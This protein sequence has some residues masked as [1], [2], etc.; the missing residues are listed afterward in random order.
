MN[1]GRQGDR[2]AVGTDQVDLALVLRAA[3]KAEAHREVD[4]ARFSEEAP[5]GEAGRAPDPARGLPV[6][7]RDRARS[8]GHAEQERAVAGKA[9]RKF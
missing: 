1:A 7:D 2:R 6:D 4:P 9:M 8:A 3:N 5:V